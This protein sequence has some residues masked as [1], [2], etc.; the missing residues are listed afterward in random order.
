[1]KILRNV[2]SVIVILLLSSFIV[3]SF[4]KKPNLLPAK[5]QLKNLDLSSVDK[6]MIVSHPG[7]ESLW[8]GMHLLEDNYLVVCVSC[9]YDKV[10]K[11][12][13]IKVM[14]ISEDKFIMLGYSDKIYT[15]L[16]YKRIK[17]QLKNIINYK[18]WSLVVTHNFSGEYGNYQHKQL[19]EI[20]SNLTDN[21]TYFGKFYK[22]IDKET[23]Y[24]SSDINKK[25]KMI[26]VYGK[27]YNAYKQMIPFEEWTDYDKVR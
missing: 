17:K 4:V 26:N 21:V 24:K 22:K 19:N 2:L 27:N 11:E 14:N 16:N 10:D 20:V 25:V 3:V 23:V 7:D 12:N 13:F 15:N 8:G 5:A 1:M 9:G 6:L 18:D